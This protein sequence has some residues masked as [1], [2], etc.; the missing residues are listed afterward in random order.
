[1]ED[2]IKVKAANDFYDDIHY[3]RHSNPASTLCGLKVDGRRAE[4][5]ATCLRC[6][7]FASGDF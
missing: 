2:F 1:M 6:R 5:E 3:R 4:G 7:Q